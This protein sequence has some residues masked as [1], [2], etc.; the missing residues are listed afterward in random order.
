MLPPHWDAA[1]CNEWPMCSLCWRLCR[2]QCSGGRVQDGSQRD[3][4]RS[5]SPQK[6]FHRWDNKTCQ[7]PHAFPQ[8]SG[9]GHSDLK[10]ISSKLLLFSWL[11]H[12]WCRG[13]VICIRLSDETT[14]DVRQL[15]VMLCPWAG[16]IISGNLATKFMVPDTST[17][18]PRLFGLDC[19][20]IGDASLAPSNS[21]QL[22]DDFLPLRRIKSKLSHA[23]L[24]WSPCT[25]SSKPSNPDLS[26]LL[27]WRQIKLSRISQI[28]PNWYPIQYTVFTVY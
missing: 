10:R 8:A 5:A 3:V 22:R 26:F 17:K 23:N 6:V 4:Q 16:I 24:H 12:A 13:D 21:L 1:W 15:L 25:L 11:S 20:S 9:S 14:T 27:S 7:F 2:R 18:R 28:F 19:Q